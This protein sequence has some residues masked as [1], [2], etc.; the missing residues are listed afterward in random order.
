MTIILYMY[1]FMGLVL[2]LLS[3]PLVLM[4]IPPNPI[5]GFRISATLS[6]RELWYAVNR[7]SGK[8][9][10][11][12]GIVTVLSAPLLYLVPGISLDA[13]ALSCLAV[14]GV[15]LIFGLI[16]SFRFLQRYQ[17]TKREG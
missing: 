6:D 14:F 5:Y 8:R 15:T 16:Q 1:V 2:C 3:I 7:Y 17:E 4:K 13:Y 10:F 11:L 9:L 12:A